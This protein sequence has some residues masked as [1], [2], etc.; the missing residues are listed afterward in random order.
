MPNEVGNKYR[1][2]D[3]KTGEE[4]RGKFF[5]LRIDAKDPSE[6]SIVYNT[7]RYYSEMHAAVGHDEYADNVMRFVN[8]QS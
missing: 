2:L 7:L 8:G 4:K 3:A 1:I 6:S 5:C